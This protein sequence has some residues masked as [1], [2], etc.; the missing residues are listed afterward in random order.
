[1]LHDSRA[2][3]LVVSPE[4]AATANEAIADAPDLRQVITVTDADITP[5]AS[6]LVHRLADIAPSAGRSGAAY[7]TWEDSPALWLYTSG[8]TGLPKAA[9]HRHASIRAVAETYAT[10]V[11]GVRPDDRCFSVAKLF[12]AYGIGNSLWFPLSVGATAVLE[13]RRPTPQIVAERLVADQPTLF[14][15]GPAFFSAILAAGIAPETFASVRLATSAGESLPAPLQQR[16]TDRYGVPIID[17][18]G[19]TEALHIFLSNSPDDIRP[20]TTGKVV[21]GYG[22]QLLDENDVPVPDGEPGTLYVRGPSLATGYWCRD[23]LTRHVFRGEWLRTGDTYVRDADGY[24][25]CLG[26]EADL[27]KASGIWVSPMEVE[28]RLTEH[29]TVA[30]AVVVGVHDAE[31]LETPVAFVIL[32]AGAAAEPDQLI[33]WCKDGL[34]SYK[35]PRHVFVIDELPTNANG[36]IQRG[37][38]RERAATKLQLDAGLLHP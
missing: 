28:G 5:P 16:F 27:I 37:V 26:R 34:A 29:S 2:T 15:G 12:F 21:P 24:Y 19:S 38:L 30:R 20:G 10:N 1:V 8:T 3:T 13:S 36:K 18:I 4:F 9:M 22:L 31:G 17:G 7:E 23:D 25:M 35:R 33:A 11:L 14:F 32:E 6:V